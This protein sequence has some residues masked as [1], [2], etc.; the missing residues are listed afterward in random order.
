MGNTEVWI[1][2]L[3]LPVGLIRTSVTGQAIVCVIEETGHKVSPQY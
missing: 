1:K 2:A 3:G